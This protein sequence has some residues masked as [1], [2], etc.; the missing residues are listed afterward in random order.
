M[1]FAELGERWTTIH[2][3]LGSP[4]WCHQQSLFQCAKSLNALHQRARAETEATARSTPKTNSPDQDTI[5]I[6]RG[7]LAGNLAAQVPGH[8]LPGQGYTEPTTQ[9][10]RP[11][12]SSAGLTDICPQAAEPTVPS[13]HSSAGDQHLGGFPRESH[14]SHKGGGLPPLNCYRAGMK[15]PYTSFSSGPHS[16]FKGTV[17]ISLRLSSKGPYLLCIRR[18]QA[19]RRRVHRPSQGPSWC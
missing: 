13:V 19:G 10:Q 6:L 4:T 14:T 9:A 15:T 7:I 16:G 5:L 8:Q 11:P 17:T 2:L 12:V 18:S 3:S 1:V